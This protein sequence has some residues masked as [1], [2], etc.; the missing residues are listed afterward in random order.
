MMH[1]ESSM[2]VTAAEKTGASETLV[3]EVFSG[4]STR[5]TYTLGTGAMIG[6]DT[7]VDVSLD[8]YWVASRHARIRVDA[9]GRIWISDL[10]STYGTYVNGQRIASEVRLYDGDRIRFG[11]RSVGRFSCTSAGADPNYKVN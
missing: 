1:S 7:S 10:G 5:K 2:V 9:S 4:V 8:D 3:L 6:S 11:F